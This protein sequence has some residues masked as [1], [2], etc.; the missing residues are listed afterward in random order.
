[1][2]KKLLEDIVRPEH[3][4]GNEIQNHT[5][6]SL[7]HLH[8]ELLNQKNHKVFEPFQIKKKNKFGRLF[9]WFVALI[10]L[11][12]LVFSIAGYLAKA[13]IVLEP[14]KQ[15]F[16]FSDTPVVAEKGNGDGFRFDVMTISGEVNSSVEKLEKN[17]VN[18][19]AKGSVVFYNSTKKSVSLPIKTKLLTPEGLTYFT[20][21]KIVIP[22]VK[23]VK[24]IITNGNIKV[25]IEA[26][27]AGESYNSELK[28]FIIASYK[29]TDKEHTIYA[30]SS[31]II[32]GGAIGGAYSVPLADREKIQKDLEQKLK[33]KLFIQAKAQLPDGHIIFN[34]AYNFKM[35]PINFSGNI[36]PLVLS[37]KADMTFYLFNIENT[38]A[39]IANSVG[40]KDTAD[41]YKINNLENLKV[42]LISNDF[43][44]NRMNFLFNGNGIIIWNINDNM[45]KKLLAGQKKSEVNNIL[46]NVH[47]VSTATTTMRPFWQSKLPVDINKITIIVKE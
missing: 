21:Q 12:L 42:S 30:R 46:K 44:S 16:S 45:I 39:M 6:E 4:Y 38:E 32:S 2:P 43:S 35:N 8:S 31:S 24:G 10:C 9:L 29:G 20:S 18:T 17:I 28:D 36:N 37:A 34:D 23:V 3:E 41:Q 26:L 27:E 15:V 11:F 7:P 1:M 25:G 22:S 33:E 19:K 40:V 14:Y 47:S 13:S 5:F